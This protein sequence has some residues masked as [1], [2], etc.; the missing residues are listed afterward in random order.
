M[1]PEA[2]RQEIEFEN[3]RVLARNAEI[4]KARLKKHKLYLVRLKGGE[5]K[6]P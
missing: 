2:I 6:Q 5:V 4:R 3:R 1:T